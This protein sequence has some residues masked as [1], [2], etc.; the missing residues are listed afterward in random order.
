MPLR[1]RT[2]VDCLNRV[3]GHSLEEAWYARHAEL[4]NLLGVP[5]RFAQRVYASLLLS[6]ATNQ[7]L[8]SFRQVF[9]HAEAAHVQSLRRLR[10]SHALRQC[11]SQSMHLALPKPADTTRQ[12][13]IAE[14]RVCVARAERTKGC[15]SQGATNSASSSTADTSAKSRHTWVV[16]LR[17]NGTAQ[18]PAYPLT[19]K[20]RAPK[21]WGCRIFDNEADARKSFG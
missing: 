12:A 13:L 16:S 15:A 1:G 2:V 19:G 21:I 10:A 9:A 5:E 18:R 11:S 20:N 3:G 14:Q 8:L 4:V 7:R 17:T 6:T